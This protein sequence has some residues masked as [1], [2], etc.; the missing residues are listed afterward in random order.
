[1]K[2]KYTAYPVDSRYSWVVAAG[3]YKAIFNTL[4]VNLLRRGVG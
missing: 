2:T 4:S 3:N 1:M